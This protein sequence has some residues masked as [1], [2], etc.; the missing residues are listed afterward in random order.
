[1]PL[2]PNEKNI[3]TL[4]EEYSL[5]LDLL[6]PVIKKV[7]PRSDLKST[8]L[9]N[10]KKNLDNFYNLSEEQCNKLV[11]IVVKYTSI[12]NLLNPAHD[13]EFTNKEILNIIMQDFDFDDF[14][15]KYNDYFFELSMA[16]RFLNKLTPSKINLGTICDIIIDNEIAIECKYIHSKE[17]ICKNITS[18]MKQIDSRVDEKLARYGFVAIDISNVV[19]FDSERK[20]AIEH[21]NNLY[22]DNQHNVSPMDVL[23]SKEF[24]KPIMESFA[25]ATGNMFISAINGNDMSKNLNVNT[26]AILIQVNTS[27]HVETAEKII[28]A[29]FRMLDHYINPLLDENL[30]YI[31]KQRIMS[32]CKGI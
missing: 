29:P 24:Q 15:Q 14:D 18:A 27:F 30:Q 2:I 19:N 7:R 28:P 25:S 8:K 23:K 11:P 1:M 6:T 32:L 3:N 4:K 9:W 20:F 13:I 16:S 10:I 31:T 17:N 22:I 12:N 26:R 5:F 21:F